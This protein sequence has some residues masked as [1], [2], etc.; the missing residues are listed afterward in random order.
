MSA[1][2]RKRQ[3][4]KA[5]SRLAKELIESAGDMERTGLLDRASYDKIASRLRGPKK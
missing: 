3:Q 5:P 1:R 4:E 2:A